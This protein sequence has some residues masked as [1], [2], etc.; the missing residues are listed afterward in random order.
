MKARLGR[1]NSLAGAPDAATSPQFAACAGLIQ[2]AAK[3]KV[4]RDGA[5]RSP[6]PVRAASAG[7]FSGVGQWLRENF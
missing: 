4:E 3:R 1:P 5:R 7:V 2:L 6:A